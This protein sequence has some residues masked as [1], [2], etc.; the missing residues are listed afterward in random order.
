MFHLLLLPSLSSI[1]SHFPSTVRHVPHSFYLHQPPL[2]TF[3]ILSSISYSPLRSLSSI[4]SQFPSI[5]LYLLLSF[6]LYYPP[7]RT[8]LLLPSMSYCPIPRHLLNLISFFPFSF[9]FCLIILLQLSHTY[10]HQSLIPPSS[11]SSS[12]SAVGFFMLYVVVVFNASCISVSRSCCICI[13]T[14][15]TRLTRV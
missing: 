13:W 1:I 11:P 7:S 12:S 6:Y 15:W 2:F 10:L 4:V 9:L 3:F 8:S 5:I 14:V